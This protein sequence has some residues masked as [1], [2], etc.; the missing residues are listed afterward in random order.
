MIIRNII[1]TIVGIFLLYSLSKTLLDYHK[2]ISFYDEY[3]QE[4][5]AEKDKNKKLKK[6][7]C[8]GH[9][10]AIQGENATYAEEMVYN[11]DDQQL[12]M[13][14]R[15]KIIFDTGSTKGDGMFKGIGK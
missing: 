1:I 8:K 10:K 2:K 7:I 11:G 9:V 14:G 15:P 5:R 3:N 6:V 12:V 4:Y 13:T